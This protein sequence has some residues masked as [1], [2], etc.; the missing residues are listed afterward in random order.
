MWCWKLAPLWGFKLVLFFPLGTVLSRSPLLPI[1]EKPAYHKE[2]SLQQ[3]NFQDCS[4]PQKTNLIFYWDLYRDS[5]RCRSCFLYCDTEIVSFSVY[6][7]FLR[8]FGFF[9]GVVGDPSASP[10]SFPTQTVTGSTDFLRTLQ[11]PCQ[12]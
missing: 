11:R 7:L 9:Y 3:S 8:H 5:S 1:Q 6:E 10:H 2:A 4:T 12:P